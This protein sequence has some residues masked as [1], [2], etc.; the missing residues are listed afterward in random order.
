MEFVKINSENFA[1]TIKLAAELIKEGK[2]IIFP[3]DTVLGLI[4]DAGN[5]KAVEKVFKIKRRPKSKP[6][7]IF[8]RDIKTAKE[9]AQINKIQEE[10]LEKNW[11]GKVTAVLRRR[12]GPRLYGVDENTIALR[13]PNHKFLNVLLKK[14][15][16]PLAQTSVNISGEPEITEA[17]NGLKIFKSNRY[18]P[19]L[20]IDDGVLRKS[21][22][23]KIIDLSGQKIKILSK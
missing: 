21:A 11:P 2:V 18:R 20:I 7:S 5:R 12:K 13:I 10:F 1:K 23:S 6:I 4:C 16:I 15:K 19:D 3:T 17:K 22:P 8:V 14:I 9:L